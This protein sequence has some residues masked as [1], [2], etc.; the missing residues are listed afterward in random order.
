MTYVNGQIR[1]LSALANY[2]RAEAAAALFPEA[3]GQQ[4]KADQLHAELTRIAFACGFAPGRED[5]NT[6][7]VQWAQKRAAVLRRTFPM[8][9]REAGL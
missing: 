1:L 4:I 6:S 3:T 7:V 8:N 2:E 9:I 5:R